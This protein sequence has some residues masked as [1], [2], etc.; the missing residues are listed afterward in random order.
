MNRGRVTQTPR[1]LFIL[2]T[3]LLLIPLLLSQPTPLRADEFTFDPGPT[4]PA[5]MAYQPSA[6]AE[7]LAELMDP[8]TIQNPIT[9]TISFPELTPGQLSFTQTAPITATVLTTL[10][11][12]QDNAVTVNNDQVGVIIE[13]DTFTQTTDLQFTL[14]AVAPADPISPTLPVDFPTDAYLYETQKTFLSFQIEALDATTAQPI[15]TFNKKVRLS[16]DVRDLGYT[17][18]DHGT[19]FLAYRDETNPDEWTE[20]PL[21]VY[22]PGFYSADVSHFS[23]WTTGWRPDGWTMGWNPPSADGFSGAAMYSY[24]FQLPPGRN[25]LQPSLALSYSNSALNGAIRR[26]GAGT[27]ASGWSLSQITI[28]RT[29][30][31]LQG[32]TSLLMPDKFRLVLNGT[33]YKLTATT[34]TINGGTRYTADN[35]PQ[36]FVLKY[37]DYWVVITGEGTHYRLG[38]TAESRTQHILYLNPYSNPD[39]QDEGII[40]WHVDTVTDSSGN[41]I[42]YEYNNS[43]VTDAHGFITWCPWEEGGVCVVQLKT[44]ASR[45]T[46]VY[47]NFTNRITALPPTHNVARLNPANAATHLNLLYNEEGSRFSNIL[48]YHNSSQPIREYAVDGAD[49]QV[50]NP[51]S[52]CQ[53][54]TDNIVSHTRIVNT[55][56]EYGWNQATGE[57]YSLPPTTFGYTPRQNYTYNDQPCFIYKHLQIVNNGYGGSVT[58][59]YDRDYRSRGN[60]HNGN[61]GIEEYPTIGNSHYVIKVEQK[62]GRGHTSTITY[63]RQNRCY[64]QRY[65]SYEACP[66]GGDDAPEYGVL[67]GFGTVKTNYYDLDGTTLEHQEETHYH[68][69]Y[70]DEARHGRPY[71]QD[72]KD[73]DGDVRQRTLTTYFTDLDEFHPVKSVTTYWYEDGENS[74]ALSQKVTYDYDPDFQGGTQYGNLTHIREYDDANAT[75]PYRITNRWYTPNINT[76]NNF[77]LVSLMRSEAVYATENGTPLTVQYNYYDGQSLGTAPSKGRITRTRIGDPSITCANVPGGGGT[78]CATARRTIDT[79][80]TYDDATVNFGNLLTTSSYTSYGYQT[81]DSNWN[82]LVDIPPTGTART[83]TLVYNPVTFIYPVQV[84]DPAGYVT[85]FDVYGFKNADDVLISPDGFSRQTGLLKQVTSANGQISLYEYDPFGRLTNVYDALGDRGTLTNPWDG[86][87]V[88]RYQYYDN[89]WQ[90]AAHLD[91]VGNKPFPIVVSQRPLTYHTGGGGTGYEFKQVTYYDGLG[92]PIQSQD[93]WVAVNG[94]PNRQDR[95]V[96]TA[97]DDWG[98][99]T[100]TTIPYTVDTYTIRTG[101]VGSGFLTDSCASQTHTTTVYDDMGRVEEVRDANNNPTARYAYGITTHVTVDSF[102]QLQRTTITDANN[103]ITSQF[104]NSRGQLV[105]VR[106]FTGT[107]STANPVD[108]YVHLAD[109]RYRYDLFGNLLRVGTSD[110]THSQPAD[111]SSA[112]LRA[113]TMSYDAFGRKTGMTDPDMGTWAYN[114]DAA[115]NLTRQQDAKGQVLCFFYDNLNRLTSRR[116]DS[117]VNGCSVSDNLRASYSYF[118][119]GNGSSSGQ[120]SEIRWPDVNNR[121]TFTYNPKGLLSTHTRWIDG[122]SYSLTYGGYDLFNRP[123]SLTY[124]NQEVVTMGYD[125]EGENNLSITSSPYTPAGSLVNGV[126]YNEQGQLAFLDRASFDTD[127]TYWPLT[128]GTEGNNNGRL[129]TIQHGA[130]TDTLPD[131]KYLYDN[132][133]NIKTLE[134]WVKPGASHLIDTQTFTYDELNRLKSANGSGYNPEMIAYS[135]TYAYDRL[136]NIDERQEKT[137]NPTCGPLWNV[138]DYSYGSKP[139]AVTSVGGQGSY[140]Y[141]TNGNMSS[142][143][144]GGITYTQ[145]YDVENRLVSVMGGGNSTTFA[146]DASGQRVKTMATTPGNS[147]TITYYP[148]PNYEEEQQQTW[149]PGVCFATCPGSWVT[150]TTITRSLYGLAGQAIATRVVSSPGQSTDGLFYFLGDHL[151]STRLLTNTSGTPVADTKAHFLPYGSYRGGAPVSELT[152]TGFTGH[153]HNGSL[154]LIYMNARFYVPSMARFLTADTIVPDPANPQAFNRFSYVFNRPTFYNDPSGHCPWCLAAIGGAIAGGGIAY[155]SQVVQNYQDG[156]TIS[157]ALTTNIDVGQIAAGAV[158]GAIIGGTFGA[159]AVAGGGSLAGIGLLEAA[160]YGAVS[161][162]VAGQATSLTEATVDEVI[163]HLSGNGDFELGEVWQDAHA[164]GFLD[165]ETMLIDTF[166][167]AVGGVA[168]WGFSSLFTTLARNAGVIPAANSNSTIPT[169]TGLVKAGPGEGFV[170]SIVYE[171][172]EIYLGNVS[173]GA[174]AEFL[175]LLNM[176]GIDRAANFLRSQVT[177]QT[178]EGLS[179]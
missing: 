29:G 109:T 53:D 8:N 116:H 84:T 92:R 56:T 117:P 48:I 120:V 98:R 135:Q 107:G 55:I 13:S 38:Y 101:G 128:G 88:T 151:G 74:N 11:P 30:V 17:F 173:A 103:H 36:L 177:N 121:E 79:V 78:G 15:E 87:P 1:P 9:A 26:V 24:P 64:D 154:G 148:F 149:Y 72:S 125:R 133:G 12:N 162:V 59:T 170:L 165:P 137:C 153:K 118:G 99:A 81:F 85:K 82:A 57:R 123:T 136:G 20:V 76:A 113:T 91:P 62:D 22:Q 100:C 71:Q 114:Y 25:G 143:T 144:E 96:T 16:I 3:F 83:T 7:T 5:E 141:D 93:R 44:K 127:Y 174:F 160:G 164:S 90:G 67:A 50:I 119:P 23:D 43:V 4:G 89:L 47:Y 132:V 104:T 35:G 156:M 97:Y 129:Y 140:S 171:Q 95:I 2:F 147:R 58:F 142:R 41:Q 159:A 52:G 175:R 158:G 122:H 19:F 70:N 169:I 65:D 46:D 14:L 51:G 34:E 108:P 157:E 69:G 167:G 54:G 152:D 63:D 124:P 33:G 32:V 166:S 40:E 155:V 112:W 39:P 37:P 145:I 102:T 73:S 179:E 75:T 31:E 163:D 21:T 77:W 49:Q 18:P 86:N 168:A 139:Q 150:D 10:E 94:E 172:R 130:T 138:Y 146:Y 68:T 106:E 105:L 126:T 60:F 110:W 131:F 6:E 28:V 80:Y 66:T 176:F 115:S 134:T 42:T 27:V 61:N 111:N 161:Y 45:L 178:D